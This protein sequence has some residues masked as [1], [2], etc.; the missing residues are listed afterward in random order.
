MR[1]R[2]LAIL[3][4][5]RIALAVGGASLFGA[6][7]AGGGAPLHVG[8]A[9]S[10]AALLCAGCSALN[11]VQE[12]EQDAFMER[13]ADRPLPAGRMTSGAALTWAAALGGAGLWLFA[14]AGGAVLLLLGLAVV[15]AYNGLYTPLKR[16]TP[17]GLLVGGLAGALPPLTG[18]IAAGGD[19]GA[20]LIVAVTGVVY[21]WQVPHF[22]LLAEG[23]REEYRR[24]G[25]P[26][27]SVVLPARAQQPLMALWVMAYFLGLCWVVTLATEGR[28]GAGTVGALL[29]CGLVV[30]VVASS[31]RHARALVLVNCS[32][33]LAM[34][35]LLLGAWS[36]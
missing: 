8:A 1:A 36:F 30:A 31:G 16:L 32:M 26:L 21:L 34:G 4:R 18:W 14:L 24:A 10:G 25:F 29:V 11:Q 9:A 23:R 15:V 13:T 7:L 28:A 6:L 22:W 17:A 35:A 5:S 27:P 20:P 19:P 3:G 12:K 2:D 33:P